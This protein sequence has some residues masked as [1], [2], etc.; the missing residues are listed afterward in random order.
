MGDYNR[1]APEDSVFQDDL[2]LPRAIR[3][4]LAR[5]GDRLPIAARY[6]D[7]SDSLG[8]PVAIAGYQ[9]N[10]DINV[11]ALV[12]PTQT[13]VRNWRFPVGIALSRRAYLICMFRTQ[14]ASTPSLWLPSFW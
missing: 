3:N 1:V 13:E 10:F 4:L 11:E 8:D 9:D 2:C 7:A 6:F 5:V 14:T 12:Y